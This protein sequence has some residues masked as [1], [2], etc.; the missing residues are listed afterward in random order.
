MLPTLERSESNFHIFGSVSN[1][2]F[3]PDPKVLARLAS[4]FYENESLKKS[5]L[6]SISRTTWPY[7]K[8]YLEWMVANNRLEY[9]QKNESYKPTESGWEMFKLIL[10][11]YA[12]IQKKKINF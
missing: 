6:H 3:K 5:Q 11:F 12:Q 2:K 7:L 4:A 9:D 1:D 8:K 10:I